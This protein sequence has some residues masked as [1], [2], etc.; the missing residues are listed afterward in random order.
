MTSYLYVV[1]PQISKKS[2]K[3]IKNY[4]VHKLGALSTTERKA[5]QKNS[6]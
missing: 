1:K 2:A 3:V 4:K 5:W 6:G